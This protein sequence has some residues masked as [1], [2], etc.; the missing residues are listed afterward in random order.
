LQSQGTIV[1]AFNLET[2]VDRLLIVV[3]PVNMTYERFLTIT[4]RVTTLR[5][6]FQL[7]FPG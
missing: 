6:G 7:R 1:G 5:I 2:A 4:N 3:E